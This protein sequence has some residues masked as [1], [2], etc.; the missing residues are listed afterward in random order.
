MAALK[1]FFICLLFLL[2]TACGNKSGKPEFKKPDPLL[3]KEQMVKVLTELHLLE[4]SVNLRNAQNTTTNKKD[5][6][7]Y[8]DFFKKYGTT[9]AVF[10]ENFK[11]YASQP[12]VLSQLYDQVIIDLTRKEAAEERNK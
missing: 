12:V 4:A 8:S 3:S 5:T 9:Y 1:S 7:I 2:L 6:L 11:Y 10:Q